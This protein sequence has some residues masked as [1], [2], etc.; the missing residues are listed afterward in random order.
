MLRYIAIRALQ[1][2]VS[3]AIITVV[4]FSLT[5]FLGDP[6]IQ[7]LP[8]TYTPAEYNRLEAALGYD[9]PIIVQ[10]STFVS[11][12]LRGNLGQSIRLS[13]PVTE[14]LAER[15]PVTAILAILA[16]AIGYTLALLLGFAAG[17][18]RSRGLRAM[19]TMLA[20]VGTAMPAFAVG[21]IL[22]IIFAVGLRLFPAGGWGSWSQVVLPVLTLSIWIF[23]STVRIAR[24]TMQERAEELY[25]TLAKT[26]GLSAGRIFFRHAF[27]PSLPP[28]I[29]YGAVLA[30]ALFSGAVVTEQL[31]AIPGLGNLAVQSVQDRDQP[32]V[33]GVVM[34]SAT[35][36]ILLNLLSDILSAALDPRIRLTR[37]QR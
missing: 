24:S 23:A 19:T 28:V 17:Y 29:T 16:V 35:V 37:G 30:G 1:G 14:I 26:K 10:F 20:S 3:L 7:L 32:V 25:I 9:K 6:V 2:V 18:S 12:L 8:P 34:L 33:I 27:R 22:I 11:D 21:I 13:R 36:F 15:F 31:F 5:R 4:T